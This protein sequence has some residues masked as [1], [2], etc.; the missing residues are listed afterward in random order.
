MLAP[1]PVLTMT[2][3]SPSSSA[4]ISNNKAMGSLEGPARQT[5]YLKPVAPDKRGRSQQPWGR[6][7]TTLPDRTKVASP[8]QPSFEERRA[9]RLPPSG[10]HPGQGSQGCGQKAPQGLP[11][12]SPAQAKH[13]P[14]E[15]GG[16]VVC[17]RLREL[18]SPGWARLGLR[19]T[20]DWKLRPLVH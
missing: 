1:Q 7:H 12:P 4:A 14:V 10:V 11:V 19:S 15:G 3:A 5:P 20:S 17:G 9:G 18:S 8:G 13:A 2:S 16:W 6:G